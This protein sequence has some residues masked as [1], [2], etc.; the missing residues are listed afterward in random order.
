[1]EGDTARS[2]SQWTTKATEPLPGV[3]GVNGSEQDGQV[4]ILARIHTESLGVCTAP[5]SEEGF[6]SDQLAELL[7]RQLNEP[8]VERLTAAGMMKPVALT[9][10]GLRIEPDA[11]PF[12]REIER[13]RPECDEEG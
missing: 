11:W 5:L 10:A 1:M 4:W 13:S 8:I 12:L 7:W 3:T 6:S 2:A 9:D